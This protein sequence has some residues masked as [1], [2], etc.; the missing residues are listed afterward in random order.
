MA[1]VFDSSGRREESGR[2]SAFSQNDSGAVTVF[3]VVMFVLMIGFTGM[4]IDV[5]RIMNI[6]SQASSYVDRA[7]LTAAAELD[8]KSDALDRAVRAAMG[9]GQ[10][11]PLVPTGFR[12]SFSGDNAVT[13]SRI[14]FLS[15]ITDDD[16]DPYARSPFSGD[17]PVCEWTPDGGFDCDVAEASAAAAFALV[18]ATTETESYIMFP[19]ARI[20]A[21]GIATQASVAPQALAGFKQEVCNVV[22]LFMCNP[23]ESTNGVGSPF[24]ATPGQ[25]I[26]GKMG[27]SYTPGNFGIISS[28]EGN[29]AAD[30]RNAV[31]RVNP[32]TSCI[33][34]TLT[35]KP[36]SS[37][38]PVDQ[39]LNVR[40]DIFSGPMNSNDP[41]LVPAPN[42]AKG[43]AVQGNGCISNNPSLTGDTRPLPR[44]Q[45]FFDNTN[46]A[47]SPPL[48]EPNR[49]G[50]GD[51][52]R[53]EDSD[54]NEDYWQHSHPGDPEPLGYANMTR[55][56]LYRHE[57]DTAGGSPGLVDEPSEQGAPTC[58][59]EI[60]NTD[61]RA[62]RR[63]LIVASAN[64]IEHEDE[65]RGRSS[66][67]VLKFV[68]V[69]MTEP[70]GVTAYDTLYPA[71]GNND[72]KTL[73][74]EFVS[75]VDPG[76]DDGILH[77]YP[78]LYR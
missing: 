54:G 9:D 70:I 4:I 66:V 12:L 59:S 34:A 41:K 11:G 6:H 75:E 49:F 19:I 28:F 71:F 57:I 14:V 18:E 65:L 32:N 23:G 72:N 60:P 26:L 45:C 46:C 78:V 48:G 40:F 36:G 24:S 15:A 31:G 35:T 58:S 8:G 77:E 50:S 67:P 51:W 17:T 5:G 29:G 52:Q 27:D 43:L 3:V 47:D 20:F 64:C 56:Q 55:Y 39:G 63:V 22:P 1:K 44:D 21:P 62:D 13:A 73:F 25:Q 33:S 16:Q 30:W 76:D 53:D 42:V 61:S 37:T 69:F 74:Y 68:K 7:A 2:L 38:G 10:A